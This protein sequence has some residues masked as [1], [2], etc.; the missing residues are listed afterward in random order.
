[1]RDAVDR[2]ARFGVAVGAHP[3]YPDRGDFGRVPMSLDL[4]RAHRR[5]RAPARGARRR[6]A[7]TSATSSRTARCTTGHRRC[8]AGRRGRRRRRRPLRRA[9]HGPCPCSASAARSSGPRPPRGLPFVR[10]AFLDRGYRTDGSLV[11]RDEPGAL[12]DDPAVVA[13]RALRL[14]REGV[15]EAIDGTA[16]PWMRHPCACTATRPARSRWPARCAPR[17]TPTASRCARRGERPRLPPPDGRSRDPARGRLARRRA[18]AARRARSSPAPQG[19][20]D[21]VPA[22]RTVLVRVDPARCPL[23]AA[24]SWVERADD[25]CRI[26]PRRP[27]RRGRRSTSS[28]T[29]PTSPR[30]PRCWELTPTNWCAGTPRRAGRSRSPASPPAS[31]TW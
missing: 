8:G 30:P 29:A 19:V 15:V 16:S 23:A 22:A 21:I 10:E 9:R 5:D 25:G 4:G 12:L 26:R 17:S 1:M 24:R 13:A 3:S 14:V 6:R 11:P 2:A 18:R 31:A 28:T 7:P 27:S 20:V